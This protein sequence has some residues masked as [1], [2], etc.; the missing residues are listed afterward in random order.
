ML[1]RLVSGA[2]CA[3]LL[4]SALA[5]AAGLV[6]LAPCA[7]AASAEDIET[8]ALA[9]GLFRLSDQTGLPM[10]LSDSDAALYKS[11]FRL[12]NEARWREAD[13]DI[14]RL[15]SKLLLG[16]VLAERYLSERGYHSKFAEL[17]AWLNRYADLPEAAEIYK[18]AMRRMPHGARHPRRPEGGVFAPPARAELGAAETSP[19]L[20]AAE[21]R[22]AAVL[23]RDI[24]RHVDEGAY[25]SAERILDG[26]EA[27]RLFDAAE[28]EALGAEIASGFLLLNENNQALAIAD[29]LPAHGRRVNAA[30]ERAGGLAAWRLGRFER[31]AEHFTRLAMSDSVD[32]WNRAAGAYW[33]ARSYMRA[34]DY[35]KVDHW[36]EVGARYPYTFYGIMAR[37][38]A[39][40]PFDYNWEMPAFTAADA[41][42]V[43]AVPAGVRALA[44]IQIG[45]R[46]RAEAELRRINPADP[47][48]AHA[49]LA[50]SQR[51]DMPTLAMQLAERI[52]D[53]RGRRYDAALYPIPNWAPRDGFEV[54]R[55]LVYALVRQES[56]FSPRALSVAGA[57]GLMQLMPGTARFMAAGTGYDGRRYDLFEPQ[58]NLTLGQS[59]LAHL[60]GIDDIGDNLMMIVAAY[61][62]GPGNVARWQREIRASDPLLF[63]ES[64]PNR[65][66]RQFVEHVITNYWIYRDEL[67][68]PAPALA[69]IAE[70]GWPTYASQAATPAS[71]APR[72]EDASGT[73]PAH[74]RH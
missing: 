56:K 15:H 41:G 13:R 33:A 43:G 19:H 70:G 46:V 44:L 74:G 2:A 18:L 38:I 52:T 47:D 9:P 65:E 6:S 39:G 53:S 55:A 24:R 61:N 49:L 26:K 22:R 60:M 42:H 27:R 45:E 14:E 11:I 31:A 67:G 57:R 12:Q 4:T 35:A 8:A 68:Q 66:T 3:L 51:I 59:Y 54:D 17:S 58:L 7:H 63:L 69:T 72:L 34:G 5:L 20:S 1:R 73:G 48:M 10:P 16:H 30:V 40:E 50:I 71:A 36:F 29:A 28:Y 37:K 62:G 21:R 32:S 64:I 25:D 23:E